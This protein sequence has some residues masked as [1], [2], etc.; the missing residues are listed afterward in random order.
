MKRMLKW[1]MYIEE[2]NEHGRKKEEK[3]GIAI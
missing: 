1:R 3:D 2:N